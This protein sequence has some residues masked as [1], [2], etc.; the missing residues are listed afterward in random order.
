MQGN[1]FNSNKQVGTFHS[2]LE[3]NAKNI[4]YFIFEK[5]KEFISE[6]SNSNISNLILDNRWHYVDKT[7]KHGYKGQEGIDRNNVPF[8]KLT[9]NTFK[10]GGFSES[11]NSYAVIKELWHEQHNGFSI[12]Y[13]QPKKQSLDL[14]QKPNKIDQDFVNKEIALWDILS[15]LGQSPYLKRK[16]ISHLCGIRYAKNFIA[17]KIIDCNSKCYG[18]QKIYNDGTKKFTQGLNKKGHF[19]LIGS[20]NVPK[21]INTI[22]I[23]EGVATAGSIYTA[24]L[25]PV[26]AAL[27]AYNLLHVAKNLRKHYPK[28]KIIIWADNDQWKAKQLDPK[29]RQVGN[30]GL[31]NANL[32]AFKISNAFVTFPDFSDID[33]SNVPE[34]QKPTDFNDLHQLKNLAAVSSSII[35]KPNPNLALEKPKKLIKRLRHGILSIKQ[36]LNSKKATYNS[37]YISNN[38]EFKEEINLICSPIGTGK[39]QLVENFIKA[40]KNLS[41][42]FTTHLISL[43]EDAAN[44][45]ELKSYNECDAFD[46]QMQKRIAIC[47]N[48]LGKLTLEGPLPEYDILV[49]DEIE[50]VLTRLCSKLEQKPLIFAV[51]KQ[52]MQNCKTVICLDA[53]LSEP[54]VTLVK[55]W[56]PNRFVNILHNEYEVGQG[57]DIILYEDKESL[58]VQVMKELTNKQN[59]YLAFNSKNEARK[60]FNLIANTFPEKKGLYIS[61]DTNGENSVINFFN[62]VNNES[63]KYNY[64]ICTPS[65]STGVSISNNHFNFVAGIFNSD[66]NTPNDCM[67]ALGRVRNTTTLHVFSEKRRANNPIEPKIIIAKWKQA[68]EYDMSLMGLND[69][70]DRVVINQDYEDLYTMITKRRNHGLNNF[71]YEFCL[72]AAVDGYNLQYAE[73]QLEKAERKEIKEVKN[74]YNENARQNDIIKAENIDSNT[75]KLIERKSRRSMQESIN[76]EKHKLIEFYNLSIYNETEIIEYSALDNNGKLRRKTL[77]L[78]LVLGNID[79]A[80]S[81]FKKQ[82]EESEQF[83]ADL[84]HYALRQELYQKLLADLKIAT[85]S[86]KMDKVEYR[87]SKDMLLES[88]FIKWLGNNLEVL[89]GIM[90]KLSISNI[91]NE[92][93]RLISKLLG[94]L[95][96]KQKRVGKAENGYYEIDA[97]S[98]AFMNA[99]FA[100][101]KNLRGNSSGIYCFNTAGTVLN[102]TAPAVRAKKYPNINEYMDQVG[103]CSNL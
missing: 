8:I 25:E 60:T 17:V 47:L 48:S 16:K 84:N 29:G 65:V 66:I 51:L 10:Y 97:D 35:K 63:K 71:Y 37:T 54:T 46:L 19:A 21:A 34:N 77:N 91:T 95:G 81:L 18:L 32:A 56:C 38:M 76:Y 24:T 57:R 41:V 100:K 83:L 28:T 27:D 102:T 69:L 40:N 80:R 7:K 43:V 58:Q 90:P 31:V 61:S 62:D 39:T 101:R 75:A 59:V 12:N 70:G 30:T 44:R 55:T 87:Y 96:I 98:I 22:H 26:F 94:Q 33:L 11:F 72:L 6:Q 89:Q 36:Y 15:D 2:W 45:L 42:L 14:K 49:I 86:N 52:L 50:Q 3:N 79:S 67:Q 103:Q 4:Q 1:S 85:N 13:K 9:Y 73:F 93:I 99:I 53:H 74:Y 68:H 20:Y 5:A 82:F 64:I 23:C 78:E 92:P 88:K